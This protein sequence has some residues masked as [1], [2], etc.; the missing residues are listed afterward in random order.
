M[1]NSNICHNTPSEVII[2]HSRV[3]TGATLYRCPI[4]H[5]SYYGP[6]MNPLKAVTKANEAG[7]NEV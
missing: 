7:M 3:V 5:Q 1:E 2:T 6:P 4:C